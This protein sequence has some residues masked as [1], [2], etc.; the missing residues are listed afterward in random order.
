MEKRWLELPP[1]QGRVGNAEI[2]SIAEQSFEEHPVHVIN[3]QKGQ[4]LRIVTRLKRKTMNQFTDAERLRGIST[5]RI[6]LIDCRNEDDMKIADALMRLAPRD[7]LYYAKDLSTNV[8]NPRQVS[9]TKIIDRDEI[10]RIT[11]ALGFD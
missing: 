6:D 7:W 5:I 4:R 9:A 11:K 1:V 2:L 10:V 8:P 3:A